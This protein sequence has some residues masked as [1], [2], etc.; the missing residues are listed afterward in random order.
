MTAFFKTSTFAFGAL[1]AA[2]AAAQSFEAELP[3]PPHEPGRYQAIRMNDNIVLVIDTATGEC[4]SRGLSPATAWRNEGSP[5]PVDRDS[6]AIVRPPIGERPELVLD[7][8]DTD[9]ADVTVRQR[10][11]IELPT[12]SGTLFVH[13]GDITEGQ[14][15]VS[16]RDEFGEPIARERSLRRGD[17]L[18]FE[19]ND[20]TFSLTAVELRNVLTGDDFAVFRLQA[21][22]TEA[23]DE[24]RAVDPAEDAVDDV[25]GE[26][27]TPV[28]PRQ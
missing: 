19:V 26:E 13:I 15:L 28:E 8:K 27:P 21:A 12:S 18:R 14:T 2:G 25:R 24:R 10:G 23:T 6:R 5:F 9:T 3:P 16:L 17:T 22:R 11:R 7:L 1:L 4:W 20:R